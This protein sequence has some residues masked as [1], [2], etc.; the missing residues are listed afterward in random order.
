MSRVPASTRIRGIVFA[1]LPFLAIFL[2]A[3]GTTIYPTFSHQ[4]KLLD[5]SGNPVADGNYTVMYRLYHDASGGTAVFTDTNT[6]AITD[7]YF[8]SDFGAANADPKIFSEQTWLEITVNGETLT[9]RQFLRGAPYASSV[10]SGAAIVGSEPI[11]YTFFTAN[12]LGA[13]LLV[14]NTDSSATGGSGM[15]AITSAQPTTSNHLD[16]AAVRGLA[17]DSDS[18]SSTGVYGGIFISEDFRG[19][20]ADD[21]TGSVYAAYLD[22]SIY[23]SGNCVGCMMAMIAQN[24]GSSIIEP[25]DF[26]AVS[27]VE[28]DPDYGTPVMLVRKAAH[29][30]T[31][32]GVA[33]SAMERGG[34][35]EGALT[36]FGFDLAKGPAQPGAYV[37][38]VMEGLVQA[39]LPQPDTLAIGD[40]ITAE[41]TTAD[42]IDGVAQVMSEA[43]ESGLQWILLNR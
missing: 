40:F 21:G 17:R 23:V 12:N 11:T 38:I 4:G 3:C 10:V 39:R 18:N 36:Q 43:D 27:G 16:V 2:L 31:V 42:P 14:A 25:G 34:Y 33:D 35:H 41:G 24:N 20:Y 29:G 13:S 8:N 19:L 22:G 9:P 32:I 30:D 26:V 7:G 15:T 37:S 6:V 1:F 28:V 5:S